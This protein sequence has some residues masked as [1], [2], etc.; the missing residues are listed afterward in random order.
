V[1]NL[2]LHRKFLEYIKMRLWT[3]TQFPDLDLLYAHGGIAAITGY[4]RQ[5]AS[6]CVTRDILAR[7]GA[8]IH[9]TCQPI[10]PW[11]TVHEAPNGY[12][13]LSIGAQCH[14]GKEVFFDLTEKITLG[15]GAGLGMRSVVLTHLNFDPRPERP[16][17]A[18][19]PKHAKPTTIERG[20]MVGAGAIL[21]AGVTIGESSVVGAGCVVSQDVPPFTVMKSPAPLEYAVPESIV[22]KLLAREGRERE[23]TPVYPRVALAGTGR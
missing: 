12:G 22:R 5:C 23:P 18:M 11:I 9:P 8:R 2:M 6:T 13:N 21:L 7:F 3:A 10:G 1:F 4:L 15:D 17:A 14:I 19:V 16:L 20:A